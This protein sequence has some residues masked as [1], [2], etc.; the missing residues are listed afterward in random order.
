MGP[1]PDPRRFRRWLGAKYQTVDAANAAWGTA[2]WGHTYTSFDEVSTPRGVGGAPVE[3]DAGEAVREEQIGGD[4][5]DPLVPGGAFVG[6]PFA[7]DEWR[8]DGDGSYQQSSTFAFGGPAFVAGALIGT[9]I[10]LLVNFPQ[11]KQ[12]TAQ[13]V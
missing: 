9:A 6:G 8:A 12:Q 10:A 11:L 7:L 1:R 4:V 5:E 3:G 2:F 13:I